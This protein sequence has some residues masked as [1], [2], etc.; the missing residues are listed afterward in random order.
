M[1]TS[2]IKMDGSLLTARKWRGCFLAHCENKLI[3]FG[4]AWINLQRLRHVVDHNKSDNRQI[5]VSKSVGCLVYKIMFSGLSRRLN[6]NML[7]NGRISCKCISS[8]SRQVQPSV[9][10]QASVLMIIRNETCK[11]NTRAGSFF[12][13]VARL[14][15]NHVSRLKWQEVSL[16]FTSS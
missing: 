12:F 9:E 7:I 2:G 4:V 6:T 8:G 10:K 15:F 1:E 13:L 3:Y 5:C 14:W 11:T 16:L